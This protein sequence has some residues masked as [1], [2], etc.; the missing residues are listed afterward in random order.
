M[1]NLLNSKAAS[2]VPL[3]I[4][5]ALMVS[6]TTEECNYGNVSN[7]HVTQSGLISV[8]TPLLASTCWMPHYD[9]KLYNL[10]IVSLTQDIVSTIEYLLFQ[11]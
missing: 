3:F 8:A 10:L 6:S 11:I 1:I 5:I 9:I 4:F 7:E 2:R